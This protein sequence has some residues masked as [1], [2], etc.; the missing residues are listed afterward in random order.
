[1]CPT[2]PKL[3]CSTE[4]CND[5]PQKLAIIVVNLI[6]CSLLQIVLC[7]ELQIL[8]NE[9]ANNPVYEDQKSIKKSIN[10]KRSKI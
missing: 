6:C 10:Q 7:L 1:M 4:L 5:M 2:C 8:I 9:S 3:L